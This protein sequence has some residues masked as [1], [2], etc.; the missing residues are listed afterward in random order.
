MNAGFVKKRRLLSLGNRCD[1]PEVSSIK[2]LSPAGWSRFPWPTWSSWTSST[3]SGRTD[4]SA[5]SRTSG[6]LQTALLPTYIL[7]NVTELVTT[8]DQICEFSTEGWER[9]S[10]WQR[11]QSKSLGLKPCLWLNC[12]Q[13]LWIENLIL[14]AGLLL[15]VWIWC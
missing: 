2:V 15:S 7:S 13:F 1:V 3:G 12:S 14:F 5:S 10:G 11:R 8:F 9:T 4:N 6:K